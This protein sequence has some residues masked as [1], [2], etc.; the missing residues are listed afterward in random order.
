MRGER[1]VN[2][3]QQLAQMPGHRPFGQATHKTADKARD[4]RP[5]QP[6]AGRVAKSQEETVSSRQ[7]LDKIGPHGC[8]R[9]YPKTHFSP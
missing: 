1:P 5:F 8:L 4:E 6:H 2:L 9:D 3:I 7:G